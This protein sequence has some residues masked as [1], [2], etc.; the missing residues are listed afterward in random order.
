MHFTLAGPDIG[1]RKV[2]LAGL[3]SALGEDQGIWAAGAANEDAPI[4]VPEQKEPRLVRV[5]KPGDEALSYSYFRKRVQ[6]PIT[7]AP[8]TET[9]PAVVTDEDGDVVVRDFEE[10]QVPD[11]HLQGFYE[12]AAA[13]K[14]AVYEVA[15]E[16]TIKVPRTAYVVAPPGKPELAQEAM[17][18]FGTDRA[19]P[20][21]TGVM[22]DANIEAGV[23]LTRLQR[24]G[25]LQGGGWTVETSKAT[26]QPHEFAKRFAGRLL[27]EEMRAFQ[28]EVG[29]NAD[30]LT[31]MLR[32]R[33]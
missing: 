1:V 7:P 15:Y 14:I 28:I 22:F 20:A 16:L 27:G 2:D 11:M 10:P 12:Q 25:T 18:R 17:Q 5:Y 6:E 29:S 3:M 21:G 19:P 13:G 33:L 26:E 32:R 9:L 8:V 4:D 23:A 30:R 31:A 24:A